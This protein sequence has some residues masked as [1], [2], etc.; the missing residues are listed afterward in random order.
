M[1]GQ[2]GDAV[3]YSRRVRVGCFGLRA[4]VGRFSGEV[5]ENPLPL[6]IAAVM[7]HWRRVVG[8]VVSGGALALALYMSGLA[9]LDAAA[10]FTL[11]GVQAQTFAT[12]VCGRISGCRSLELQGG[13][14]WKRAKRRVLYSLSLEPTGRE[15]QAKSAL[16]AS[17]ASHEGLL[18]WALRGES[19]VS[20]QRARP[21]APPPSRKGKRP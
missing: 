3:D 15:E 12:E 6:I 21:V 8:L 18:G 2:A 19:T 11:A 16:L 10:R 14:D 17:A 5:A 1:P 9:A 4:V 7:G 13:F 20:V